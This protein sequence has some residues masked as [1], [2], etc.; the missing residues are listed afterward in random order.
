MNTLIVGSSSGLGKEILEQKIK[1]GDEIFAISRYS[2]H[3]IYK[4][5]LNQANLIIKADLASFDEQ[6]QFDPLL[7]HIPS[8]DQIYFAIGGG[9]GRKDLIP[10]YEDML[11]VFKMNIFVISSIIKSLHESKKINESSKIC[12]I[13]SI[14]SQ[15]V[16]ASPAYS[17]AKSALNTFSK[18]MTKKKNK[19]FGSLSNFICGA[20]EG[21]GTGFDRLR[22]NNKA[23][24]NNF[25]NNRLPNGKTLSTSELAAYIITT[26]DFST[27][28]LD[29]ITIKV[30]SNESFSI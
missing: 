2:N 8:L 26:M 29:G 30:D 15:E 11:L 21:N 12:V 6:N 4:E 23:A 27:E 16:V 24:Y 22:L 28:L 19:N 17:S 18:T 13:S 10:S 1:K 5:H 25:V 14:A 9:F 7:K 3:L 20:F